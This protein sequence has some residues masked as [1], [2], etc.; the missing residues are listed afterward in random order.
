M[1][2]SQNKQMPPRPEQAAGVSVFVG[3]RLPAIIKI[4]CGAAKPIETKL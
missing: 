3:S 2:G 1:S 4:A